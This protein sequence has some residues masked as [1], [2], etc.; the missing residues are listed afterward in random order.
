MLYVCSPRSPA[1]LLQLPAPTLAPVPP[2]RSWDDRRGGV[3]AGVAA[4]SEP[5][6][7]PPP[8][9]AVIQ[10]P[11][12]HIAPRHSL[13]PLG[14]VILRQP[15]SLPERPESSSIPRSNR[16]LR[17]EANRA[18]QRSGFRTDSERNSEHATLSIEARS[19]PTLGLAGAGLKLRLLRDRTMPNRSPGEHWSEIG[20]CSTDSAFCEEFGNAVDP[21]EGK[22]AGNAEDRVYLILS[23]NA[24]ISSEAPLMAARHSL[25]AHKIASPLIDIVDITASE[26]SKSC[27]AHTPYIRDIRAANIE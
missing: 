13:G 18:P 3:G 14:G 20:S 22:G 8:T 12:R 5:L 16:V 21:A 4:H 10:S 27:P 17:F 25:K 2:G 9:P 24:R 15:Y 7:P 19:P 11:P 6:V 23:A 26:S 1:W